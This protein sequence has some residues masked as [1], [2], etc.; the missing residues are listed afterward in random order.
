MSD[1]PIQ[2]AT[3]STFKKVNLETTLGKLS[4]ILDSEHFALVVHSQKLCK[5]PLFKR[6]DTFFIICFFVLDT[7]GTD[8]E[9]REVIVGIAT[10]IDLIHYISRQELRPGSISSESN[11]GS[12]R[13]S[14]SENQ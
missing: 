9:V 4:R 5:F 6:H 13:V 1:D 3:Y 12:V 7:N 2:K 14:E 11:N 10:D 8:V